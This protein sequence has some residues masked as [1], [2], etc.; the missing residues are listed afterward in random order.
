[1]WDWGKGTWGGQGVAFSTVPVCVRVQERAGEEG[2]ILAGM[3]VKA[4]S[5]PPPI[6]QPRTM[7]QRIDMIGEKMRELRQ[8]EEWLRA[9][10]P[11]RLGN[12]GVTCEDEDKRRNSGTKT[13]TFEENCYLLLYAVSSKEDT[14]YQRQLIT[15]IR[16]MINS[17]SDVSSR[18]YTSYAQL[19]ISQRYEVNGRTGQQMAG[20]GLQS[21]TSNFTKPP[22]TKST[23]FRSILTSSRLTFS[24]NHS[25]SLHP[26]RY[27][28]RTVNTTLV[29]KNCAQFQENGGKGDDRPLGVS[30][31]NVSDV[32]K[33]VLS[34]ASTNFLPLAL[35]GGVTLGLVNP[36]LG[37]IAHRYHVAK[38]STFGIFIISGLTLR[39]DEIGAAVEA[40][41]VGLFGLAS[42][43]ML[44]PLFSRVILRLHLQPQEFVTGLAMF[45]CMPTTLSSGV[46]LTRLAGGNSAL[47]LAMT[48]F[49]NLLGIMIIPFTISRLI[50]GGAGTS[51]PA[52]QLFR[53]LIV[54]LLIPLILGK[55]IRESFKGVADFSDSNR[56]LLSTLNAILLSLV[57]WIQVSRS[58]SLL[59]MVKLEVFLVAVVVGA[60]L[61]LALMGFNA[62]SIQILC[63]ISGGSK[64]VF[65]KKENSTALLLV[66]SQKTLPVLV[67]VVD[68]LGG[69]FGESGLLVLP[70]VAAHLNQIIMDSLFVNFWNKKKESLS[71]VKAA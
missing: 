10:L 12:Y 21:I 57:P 68:Q 14:A 32:V 46:A 43:L 52:D 62:L 17:R 25:A 38:F 71:T 37:C 49:S 41:P 44:T 48:V 47:A 2:L 4:P 61:H 70:C 36:R 18:T 19:A 69:S 34:F 53:S 26:S 28:I 54:T 33:P 16:V 9:L 20:G 51:I 50:A 59:V 40:W 60:F 24:V 45:C 30:N 15:R 7:S 8:Y 11:S 42:M 13:N 58:R 64:S 22:T 1:M 6:P 29:I 65:A 63:A 3:V 5:S 55:V 23:S 27:N 66:A 39:S 35:I 56:K 67:A 31:V